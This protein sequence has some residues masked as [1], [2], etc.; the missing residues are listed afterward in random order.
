[1]LLSL[2]VDHHLVDEIGM[3]VGGYISQPAVRPKCVAIML[4][5][6]GSRALAELEE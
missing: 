4:G 2:W 5:L 6:V 3:E 1:V